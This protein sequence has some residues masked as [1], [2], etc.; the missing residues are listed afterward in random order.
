MDPP[1]HTA[2]LRSAG[3]HTGPYW[4]RGPGVLPQPACYSGKQSVASE[5]EDI[6]QDVTSDIHVTF[7]YGVV[8]CTLWK[9]NSKY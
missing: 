4:D 5:K 2:Y 3:A 8:Q 6:V 1:N 7:H 9:K